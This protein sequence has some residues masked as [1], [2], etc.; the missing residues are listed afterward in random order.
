MLYDYVCNEC[1]H[2]IIDY[3][4]SIHDDAITLCPKCGQHSLQRCITGG[5]GSFMK[6]VKTIGQLADKNY[7]NLG[8]YKRSEIE[9]KCKENI[10]Q[11]QSPLSQFGKASKTQINKMTQE[12]K[13]KYIITGD[14]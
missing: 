7:S 4:Q 2:R 10:K 8:H 6:D 3:Y 13:H 5:L 9:Q 11:Q 1:D 12:Q 14:T